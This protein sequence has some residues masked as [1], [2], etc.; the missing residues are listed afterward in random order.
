MKLRIDPD[1]PVPVFQQ[2]VDQIHFAINTGEIAPGDK[3]PSLRNL[4]VENE[5]AVNTVAKAL[6]QLEFRGVV[7]ARDRSGYIVT[8]GNGSRYQSRGVSADKT[9]VHKVV[10]RLDQ[11]AIPGAFC[12]LT[13][14]YLGGDPDRCNVIHSDGAG[15]K[16]II[17]YLKYKE[18]GDPSVFHGIAQDSIVMNL[19]DLLCVGVNGRILLSN[20]VNRN[21]LNCPGEVVSAL[22]EG[23]EKFL[24]DLR[25]HGVNIYSGGGETA[26]VGDLTG[27]LVV[28]SCAVA[29]MRKSDVIKN[30]ITPDL[31]IVGLSSTGIASYES[32]ENSGMGSNGLTSARHDMLSK[33]Y[34]EKY[35]ETFDPNVNAALVYCGPY[36]LEDALPG[37][38]LSVGEAILSPTR[39]YAPVVYR[40]MSVLG[41]QIKGM[42]HCSGGAQTKCLKFGSGIHFTKDNL[43]PTPPVFA[44]IQAASG[45]D[46]QEMYKVFNMGHRMEIFV[47]HEQVGAVIEL[48]AEF[49]IDARRIGYTEA[50][51]HNQL[52]LIDPEGREFS[53]R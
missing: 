6:R 42:V 49:G 26:D 17:A 29:I 37:S 7:T 28:D 3:L 2:I 38:S 9:E 32:T 22:I 34:A 35:P 50:S 31:A 25:D 5:I 40:L 20:T 14:D 4:A 46:W 19:D 43:F 18:T 23:S 16:S 52:S 47:P 53:Y 10:D 51:D 33:Y 11:G 21:A 13:E 41:S 30:A 36:R 8:G 45:T 24:A 12:K 27:T 15:T 44:A 39:S 1:S 48:A